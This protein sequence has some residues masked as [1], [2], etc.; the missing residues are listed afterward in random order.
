MVHGLEEFSYYYNHVRGHQHLG[1]RTPA[2]AWQ[3]V[4]PYR[5]AARRCLWFE[6][7]GGRLRGWQL[8]H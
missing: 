1:G 2:E 3:G 6:G 5:R 8:Q 4:D 7:W